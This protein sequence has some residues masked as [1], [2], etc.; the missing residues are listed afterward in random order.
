L[1]EKSGINSFDKKKLILQS[2]HSRNLNRFIHDIKKNLKSY[3]KTSNQL[4][5]TQSFFE[6]SKKTHKL[7]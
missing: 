3:A 5:T 6:H 2:K 1:D 4:E 7:K